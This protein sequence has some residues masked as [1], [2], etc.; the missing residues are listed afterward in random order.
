VKEYCQGTD[1]IS[2]ASDKAFFQECFDKW[3]STI[4]L[5]DNTY[6]LWMKRIEQWTELRVSAIMGA[7]RRNYYAECAAFIAAA[8]EVQDDM[9]HGSKNLLMQRYKSG[10]SRRRAFHDELRRYGM[11]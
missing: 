1:L 3:K 9:K 5:P 7:S 11:K 4:V 8:G 10:Y 2:S 6:E